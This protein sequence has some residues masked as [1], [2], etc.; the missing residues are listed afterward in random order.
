LPC[1]AVLLSP[2][3]DLTFSGPSVRYNAEAD[4]MFGAD[5]GD[6][7]PG[8]YCPGRSCAQPSI[9]PL[10]GD[11]GGLPP[12]YFLAGSTEV[13]LDD[14]VRAHDRALQAGTDA[15]IDV[16]PDL[17]HVFPVFDWLPEARV[18]MTAIAA[19]VNTHAPHGN[20]HGSRALQPPLQL[21]EIPASTAVDAATAQHSTL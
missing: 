4:P 19:F 15:S 16:W 2:A 5:A 18:A 8:I 13:L 20:R 17:P 11:W 12:L 10:F 14:S 3:T 9:S 6:L 21:D 1:C 7:V